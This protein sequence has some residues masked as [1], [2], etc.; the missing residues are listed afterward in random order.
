MG[1]GTR[2]LRRSGGDVRH[3]PR[4]SSQPTDT[5]I[6]SRQPLRNAG[7]LA[8]AFR[9]SE[10]ILLLADTDAECGRIIAAARRDAEQ[11]GER[12]REQAAA[13]AADARRRARAVQDAAVEQALAAARAEADQAVR[14]AAARA[15]R[16][17]AAFT[18]RQADRLMTLAVELLRALPNGSSGG[19]P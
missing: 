19:A 16:R 7:F 12:A 4:A 1:P 14:S 3:Q 2:D 9:S 10:A 5:R 6:S 17:R 18:E 8:P 11:T 13:L 15:S